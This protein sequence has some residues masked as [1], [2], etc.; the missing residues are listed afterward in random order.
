[1][2]A[3]IRGGAD[4]SWTETGITWGTQPAFG[5]AIATQSLDPATSNVWYQWDVSPFVQGKWSGNKLV[6]MVVKPVTEGST[7]TVPP[8]YAFDAKEYG[9]NGPLLQVQTQVSAATATRVD[10]YYRYSAD[11]VTWGTWTLASSSM[12]APFTASFS[13]P[14]GTGYYEFYSRATDSSSVVEPAPLAAQSA[15]YYTAAPPYTTEAIV[16]LGDLTA[17]FN[18][19]AKPA[20]VTTVPPGVAVAVTYNGSS[21]APV[22]AGTYTV[23]ATVTQAGYTGTASGVLTIGKASATVSLANLKFTYDGSAKSVTATTDPTGLAVTVT[24]NG[25]TTPPT[26]AGSYIVVATVIDSNYQGSATTT[27]TIADPGSGAA[28]VPALGPWG[29]MFAAAGLGGIMFL[30]RKPLL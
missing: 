22:N 4:D 18:G 23:T 3:E 26:A 29:I 2:S 19:T 1:M 24:Y 14:Q 27:M 16:S 21:I 25:S 15:T 5:A 13:Y 7:D 9:S 10:F 11:N 17:Q 30:R 28:A 12:T 6:S 8:S 20:S